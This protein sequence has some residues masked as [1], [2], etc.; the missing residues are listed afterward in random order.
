ML[1]AGTGTGGT[2]RFLAGQY[3]WQ[4]TAIDLTEEYWQTARWLNGLVG[5]AGKIFAGQADVT[6]LPFSD[7]AF[8]IVFS[9]PRP[10]ERGRQGALVRRGGR[11]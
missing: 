4:V 9:L 1:D 10:D 2:A 7:A 6:R 8:D 3:G 5:L 11:L